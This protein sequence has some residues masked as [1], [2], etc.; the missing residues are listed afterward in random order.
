MVDFGLWIA[1]WRWEREIGTIAEKRNCRL[2][3]H[4]GAYRPRLNN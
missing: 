4:G 3:S 2:L 1:T